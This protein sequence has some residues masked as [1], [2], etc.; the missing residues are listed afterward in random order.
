MTD[1]FFPIQETFVASVLSDELGKNTKIETPTGS[2]FLHTLISLVEKSIGKTP[3]PQDLEMLQELEDAALFDSFFKS[4]Q[5]KMLRYPLERFVRSKKE[6]KDVLE[7]GIGDFRKEISSRLDTLDQNQRPA[8]LI[9]VATLEDFFSKLKELDFENLSLKNSG[10]HHLFRIAKRSDGLYDLQV[11]LSRPLDQQKVKEGL[12]QPFIQY[13]GLSRGD[14]TEDRFLRAI[15]TR[16]TVAK[17]L[18]ALQEKF[19]YSWT[20]PLVYISTR[21]LEFAK[22]LLSTTQLPIPGI[23]SYAG[24]DVPL[25]EACYQK[26][27]AVPSL[28]EERCIPGK[29][30]QNPWGIWEAYF[31]GTDRRGSILDVKL[32]SLLQ[33]GRGASHPQSE[34]A[35]NLLKVGRERLSKQVGEDL[36]ISPGKLQFATALLEE[37]GQHEDDGKRKI[38]EDVFENRPPLVATREIYPTWNQ[39]A[40]FPKVAP[41][42]ESGAPVE[43]PKYQQIDSP[44]G[45]NPATDGIQPVLSLVPTLEAAYQAG[46]YD[47]II[48]SI[49][50]FYRRFNMDSLGDSFWNHLDPSELDGLFET[51]EKISTLYFKSSFDASGPRLPDAESGLLMMENLALADKLLSLMNGGNRDLSLPLRDLF[52]YLFNRSAFFRF[53]DPA[54]DRRLLAVRRY[55]ESD[56]EYRS[57]FST[58]MSA[59]R[60]PVLEKLLGDTFNIPSLLFVS[61]G[62]NHG[63]S[64]NIH[65]LGPGTSSLEGYYHAHEEWKNAPGWSTAEQ[66]AR[67]YVEPNV[68][69]PNFYRARQI[70]FNAGYFF[71]GT[72]VKPS[73]FV[74][75]SRS[76][77]VEYHAFNLIREEVSMFYYPFVKMQFGMSGQDMELWMVQPTIR[78]I[79]ASVFAENPEVADG[80]HRAHQ[81][82]HLQREAEDPVIQPML[83]RHLKEHLGYDYYLSGH[84]FAPGIKEAGRNLY[85]LHIAMIADELSLKNYLTKQEFEQISSFRGEPG[86]QIANTLSF[87]RSK[88]QL[89]KNPDMQLYFLNLIFEPPLLYQE[90]ML[91]NRG[92]ELER[93]LAEFIGPELAVLSQLGDAKMALSIWNS[94]PV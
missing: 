26:A 89:L 7:E 32:G 85:D 57:P 90:L 45:W 61:S 87:F 59:V 13:E 41:P 2:E 92:P 69:P 52:P 77:D 12:F 72:F 67:A 3:S 82:S 16:S 44:A 24:G 81:F 31:S 17:S 60:Q 25:L 62:R 50:S 37:I 94:A 73:H 4:F 18:D 6:F 75:D 79:D 28:G 43:T 55:C 29:R 34:K 35:L 40:I 88:T 47:G 56:F 80:L 70:A 58:D 74:R 8:F 48:S 27:A 54:L 30:A 66:M 36:F 86:V 51:L 83:D 33:F 71:R 63:T 1:S 5:T 64:T 38:Q 10:A 65:E 19:A 9:P 68:F 91:P 76:Y 84:G 53:G 20:T 93:Q 49:K 39:D 46:N 15:L 22:S 11:F 78:G 42:V 21:F 23:G 14:L